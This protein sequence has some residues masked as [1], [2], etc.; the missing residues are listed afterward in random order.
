[1]TIVKTLK[2]EHGYPHRV[3]RKN[4]TPEY[5]RKRA[6]KIMLKERNEPD[7]R[8]EKQKLHE[9]KTQVKKVEA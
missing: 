8:F 1:M 6:A 7:E 3:H 5:L 4:R 9:L 2:I